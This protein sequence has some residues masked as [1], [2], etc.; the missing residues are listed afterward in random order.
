MLKTNNHVYTCS[1]N[2]VKKWRQNKDV[3]WQKPRKSDNQKTY[4]DKS[5]EGNFSDRS[6]MIPD[7]IMKV[8]EMKNNWKDNYVGKFK[9]I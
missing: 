5:T 3:R 2:I 9:W 4:T 8:Q 7:L 1:K 6:K